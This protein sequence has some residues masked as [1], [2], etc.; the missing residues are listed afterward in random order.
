MEICDYHT[1]KNITR[2]TPLTISHEQTVSKRFKLKK[3]AKKEY[4]CEFCIKYIKV[5]QDYGNIKRYVKKNQI[6]IV[7]ILP[8][9]KL[10]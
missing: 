9:T 3:V 8:T 1:S 10:F 5:I 6:K 2:K 4:K 7:L